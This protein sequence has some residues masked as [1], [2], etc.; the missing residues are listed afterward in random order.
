[1][2]QLLGIAVLLASGLLFAR[3]CEKF[4][5]PHVTGYLLAGILIGPSILGLLSGEVAESLHLIN[6]VALAFIAFSIGSEMNLAKI[7]S[8]GSK[9]LLVTI[10]EALGAFVVVTLGLVYL[11]GQSWP[12][13]LVLG[14]IACAT[15]P[16]ATLM[17][18]RQ[19]Q[20]KGELVDVLI[21]VVALDDAV[22]II[23]FGISSSL[24]NAMLAGE[25]VSVG[26]ML[27]KP[28][29]EILLA[30]A[31]GA[32]VGL[33]YILISRMVKS[34]EET[35]AV[36]VA[37]VFGTTALALALEI[38]SLLM[39]MMV[40]LTVA[41]LGRS[42]RHFQ[43]QLDYITP[44]IFLCFFVLSGAD[45]RLASLAGVGALGLFYVGGRVLGKVSGAYFSTVATGF[46]K[47]VQRYLGL[48]L[49]P[50]AG[51][52]LGLSA[53][54]QQI[55]PAAVGSQIRTIILGATIVYELVGP[56]VAKIALQKA[57]CIET[58][59]AG[60]PEEVFANASSQG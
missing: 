4:H 50:Q 49:V 8:L 45:L 33:L 12:F 36:T 57:G 17:V 14:S 24:A 31:I 2:E 48:T 5:F 15:A 3:L 27:A 44:P 21:P 58:A 53:M 13:A 23:I 18:I 55:L 41:N 39:L 32:A 26:S 22:C 30:L 60:Q 11:F 19:Y 43:E 56:F 40:G 10:A 35:M 7:R 6:D 42:T 37:V 9:I 16:A 51:V 20:A 52:A 46:S 1:M 29:G 47:P 34:G 38:S 25:K 59:S 28:V 54:A